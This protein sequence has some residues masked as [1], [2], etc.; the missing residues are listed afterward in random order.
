MTAAGTGIKGT[1]D[2]F[3]FIS[4]QVTGDAQTSAQIV[5]QA[6]QAGS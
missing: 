2:Q 3:R 1:G 6:P 5:S 4:Q